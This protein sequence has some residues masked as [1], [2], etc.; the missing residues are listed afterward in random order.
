MLRAVFWEYIKFFPNSD[1]ERYKPHACYMYV[2][3]LASSVMI[4][5]W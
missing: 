2:T 3:E 1:I 5:I 4:S